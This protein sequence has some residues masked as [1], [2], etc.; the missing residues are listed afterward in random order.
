MVGRAWWICSR[1]AWWS[2]GAIGL[3]TV[4]LCSPSAVHDGVVHILC[5]FLQSWV[6]S[7]L[8]VPLLSAAVP[9][10]QR[11]QWMGFIKGWGAN[12]GLC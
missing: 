12:S 2:C 4:V 7:R 5:T 10:V 11:L 3:C 1:F 8:D 9:C 6:F